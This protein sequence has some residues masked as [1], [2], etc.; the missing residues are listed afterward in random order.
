MTPNIPEDMRE[1]FDEFLIET[2]E[3]LSE[4]DQHF[5]D[6]E[7]NPEDNGLLNEIFRTVHSIKGGAGFLELNDLVSVAHSSENV[8]NTL[9]NGEIAVT[10][11]IIDLVL[12]SV[13]MIKAILAQVQGED[14]GTIDIDGMVQKL[15]LML[16]FALESGV[17]APAAPATEAAPTEPESGTIETAPTET[18]PVETAPA[19]S[20]ATSTPPTEPPT[21]P[22]PPVAVAPEPVVATPAPEPEAP[23]AAPA[24]AAAVPKA[25]AEEGP[26]P[27]ITRWRPW[28][29]SHDSL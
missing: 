7:S 9:R 12:E 18:E 11:D 29:G 22:E 13:D 2:G 10:T 27:S 24:A 5:L 4:L 3:A 26:P 21:A 15:D 8:L 17:T 25:P 16:Q 28:L 14:V 6:L 20:E 23:K 1:I 19:E